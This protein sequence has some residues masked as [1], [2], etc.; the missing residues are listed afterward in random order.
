MHIGLRI[1][2]YRP[3]IPLHSLSPTG[4]YLSA[5]RSWPDILWSGLCSGGPAPQPAGSAPP[6]PSDRSRA[7]DACR[8]E[9]DASRPRPSRDGSGSDLQPT[10]RN[11]ARRCN[12]GTTTRHDRCQA[13]NC[14][15]SLRQF[16]LRQGPSVA[17]SS[18]GPL[19][20]RPTD[21]PTTALDW[22]PGDRCAPF[23]RGFPPPLTVPDAWR[24]C[25]TA[26]LGLHPSP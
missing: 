9:P 21:A 22:L 7:P 6:I 14:L 4:H 8:S 24:S 13:G 5:M 1:K 19:P 10:A 16:C 12:G 15:L 11:A 17:N 3:V 23:R 25:A 2:L 18:T 26:P 20:D